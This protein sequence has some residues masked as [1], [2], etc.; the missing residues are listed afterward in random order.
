MVG[1]I[2]VMVREAY[3]YVRR[4]SE[5]YVDGYVVDGGQVCGVII[6]GNGIHVLPIFLLKVIL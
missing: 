3:G 1:R 4:G 2:R 6:I 5:G